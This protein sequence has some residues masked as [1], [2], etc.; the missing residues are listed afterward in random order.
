MAN[1]FPEVLPEVQSMPTTGWFCQ[2]SGGARKRVT[3]N[4][5]ASDTQGVYD[6]KG[7]PGHSHNAS[8]VVSV[9]A[10]YTKY[11][12][13]GI[14]VPAN[15]W[16]H[17]AYNLPV[18]ILTDSEEPDNA[19]ERYDR[20]IEKCVGYISMFPENCTGHIREPTRSISEIR[21][22]VA[23]KSRLETLTYIDEM[24]GWRIP[25]GADDDEKEQEVFVSDFP[26]VHVSVVPRSQIQ[27]ATLNAAV[28]PGSLYIDFESALNQRY[29]VDAT[30]EGII[31]YVPGIAYQT[32]QDYKTRRA[33]GGAGAVG[34]TAA[35]EAELEK[36]ARWDNVL[37]FSWDPDARKYRMRNE[38]SVI[39]RSVVAVY[40][41]T[42]GGNVAG[43]AAGVVFDGGAGAGHAARLTVT[44][45]VMETTSAFD[46]SCWFASIS[47]E[48]AL[49]YATRG[50]G[51]TLAK[52]F[53]VDILGAGTVGP[54]KWV[55][56]PAW[57]IPVGGTYAIPG[58]DVLQEL[59]GDGAPDTDFQYNFYDQFSGLS[60]Q[61]ILRYHWRQQEAAHADRAASTPATLS[62]LGE[63][64]L[65]FATRALD[66]NGGLF[67]DRPGGFQKHLYEKQLLRDYGAA[68]A[69]Y[70][71]K[72]NPTAA[73][74]ITSGLP[75][76]L[77]EYRTPEQVEE[78]AIENRN[79]TRDA[80]LQ[81]Q[82]DIEDLQQVN[83]RNM[84]GGDPALIAV[85]KVEITQK[86]K[87][88]ED[89]R[90][91]LAEEEALV[92]SAAAQNASA[93][94][95]P[96]RRDA[97]GIFRSS[98]TGTTFK[99]ECTF[100]FPVATFAAGDA[101]RFWQAGP[102]IT[103]QARAHNF[104]GVSCTPLMFESPGTGNNAGRLSTALVGDP[105]DDERAAQLLTTAPRCIMNVTQISDDGTVTC[106]YDFTKTIP[107]E[108]RGTDDTD[109]D[110][111]GLGKRF[112]VAGYTLW[113]SRDE[114]LKSNASEYLVPPEYRH[115]GDD[116][117]QE[118]RDEYGNGFLIGNRFPLD[119]TADFTTL[120]IGSADEDG[121][122]ESF[123]IFDYMFATDSVKGIFLVSRAREINDRVGMIYAPLV[124]TSGRIKYQVDEDG[125]YEE[126]RVFVTTGKP[127][128]VGANGLVG[129]LAAADFAG[130]MPINWDMILLDDAFC[131]QNKT[132][133][134]A[135]GPF[136]EEVALTSSLGAVFQSN[137]RISQHVCGPILNPNTRIGAVAPLNYD[138]RH[139]PPELRDF[140]LQFYD[141]DWSR[142]QATSTTLNE[143]TLYEFR[144]GNQLVGAETNVL[145][146]PQF[147]E[148][149][150]PVT[151]GTFEVEI[152]SELGAPSYFCFFCRSTS[153][154]ILQ[155][156][157]IKTLSI[158]N[159]TTKKKSNVVQDLSVSQLF[160][161]TQRNVHPQAQ[162]DK[163]AFRRRQTV[164]LSTEDIGM[165][166]LDP[167]QYQKAKRVRYL[168][169]GTTDSIQGDLYIVLVYNNRGL[170]IDGR[171]LQVV[172]LHE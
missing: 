64:V 3:P 26:D 110:N 165:M 157:I 170:H 163:T 82:V 5:S 43:L 6:V 96:L 147:R 148:F 115:M 133:E 68:V 72:A 140:R 117:R 59:F 145:Y 84:V 159:A 30:A 19:T 156:P 120:R 138:S 74:I 62:K 50:N 66:K 24:G 95:D 100:G 27:A 144:D 69:P 121:I 123:Q 58:P 76:V 7:V 102:P 161:L 93:W 36:L 54:F 33:A 56:M 8:A 146:L 4:S 83:A 168:F 17:G 112:F 20:A 22:L 57:R 13:A 108:L 29:R 63:P 97:N 122:I 60:W 136:A 153:T 172:T 139:L 98:E 99:G 77:F 79:Y 107:F 73:E 90:K 89:L 124:S 31:G 61:G 16:S 45:P 75:K 91:I 94:L 143:L 71:G 166:G 9:D 142:L 12:D 44:F 14:T 106:A 171:R 28:S 32:Y 105:T 88:N 86:Q 42:Q 37:T 23:P 103:T 39:L 129:D 65:Q 51:L 137:K 46:G 111:E 162:Y 154:D 149:K 130:W 141:I 160:H 118:A 125:D 104:V 109:E 155:Q 47:N 87:D 78:D 150:R 119:N 116:T 21:T 41:A 40:K 52:Q 169:N 128:M 135:V 85:N 55:G 35:G 127:Q 101:P 158:Y 25:E 92:T 70:T 152:F 49:S 134:S 151:D 132:F 113:L 131:E 48:A 67:R 80:I 53:Q 18:G 167:D 15:V 34:L 38:V 1:Q 164:L 114:G 2:T 81:N 11:R 10:D 126:G